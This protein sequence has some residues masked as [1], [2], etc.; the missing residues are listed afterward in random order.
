MWRVV[1]QL[2]LTVYSPAGYCT[3]KENHISVTY[4]IRSQHLCDFDS[5][6]RLCVSTYVTLPYITLP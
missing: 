2:N 6:H 4:S 5:L 1:N 3:V